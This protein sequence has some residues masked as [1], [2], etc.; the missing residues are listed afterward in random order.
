MLPRLT[1]TRPPQ[2]PSRP[3]LDHRALRGAWASFTKAAQATAHLFETTKAVASAS[4][5]AAG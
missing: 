4:R 1:A 5:A 3:A 2:N